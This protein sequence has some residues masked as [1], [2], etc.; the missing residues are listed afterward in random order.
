MSNDIVLGIAVQVLELLDQQ[1]SVFSLAENVPDADF[2]ERLTAK[3]DQLQT[4]IAESGT[5]SARVKQLGLVSMDIRMA[6]AAALELG[7]GNG[8]NPLLIF[9]AVQAGL[10][11]HLV[12]AGDA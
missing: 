5:S 4:A 9:P 10:H 6:I 7:A 11:H 2:L 12:E 8:L 1:N 3:L